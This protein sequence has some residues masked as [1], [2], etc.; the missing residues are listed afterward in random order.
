[1][2][3]RHQDVRLTWWELVARVEDI[4][5]GLLVI[6]VERGDRVGIWSPTRIEWT[7]LSRGVQG[8]RDAVPGQAQ[9]VTVTG[10]TMSARVFPGHHLETG[11]RPAMSPSSSLTRAALAAC[12]RPHRVD[13]DPARALGVLARRV[14]GTGTEM[15]AESSR[16]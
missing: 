11:C 1:M 10:S 12:S 9:T 4:T 13:D 14:S 8:V 15:S 16:G 2:V 6:G 5:R 3:S 7:L